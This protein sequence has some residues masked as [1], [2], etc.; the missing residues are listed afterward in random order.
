M[1]AVVDVVSDVVGGV[2][3]IV[4]DVGG[5]LVGAVEWVVDDVIQPVVSTVGDVVQGALDNPLKTMAQIAAVVT[6]QYWM[7]PLIAGA[8]TAIKG[9]SLGDVAKSVAIA[10]VMQEVA[11]YAGEAAGAYGAETAAGIEYGTS[12]SQAAMLAAQEA[13]MGTASAIAGNVLGSAGAS[14]AISVITGQD[15]LEAFLIGGATAGAAAVLGKVKDFGN[16]AANNKV[17]ADVISS[18]I[19]A[20]LSGGNVTAA[21]MGALVASAGLVSDAIKQFDPLNGQEGAKLNAAQ[22]AILSDVLMGTA[23]A[24]LSGGDPSR[25]VQAALMKA[26]SKALGEMATEGFK[27][28]TS[29]VSDYFNAAEGKADILDGNISAQEE[30]YNNY[31]AY[32]DPLNA[33]VAEQTRLKGVYDAA[34]AAHNANPTE[35]SRNTA[36]A[37]GD[38]FDAYVTKLNKDYAETYS[39]NIKKYGDQLD[40]LQQDYAVATGDYEKAMDA[41]ADSTDKLSAVLDP[42]YLESNRAFTE[43]LDPNFNAE[44]YRKING[45][46]A[47]VDVYEDYLNRGQLEGL[48]TNDKDQAI[49]EARNQVKE[50]TGQDIPNYI[51]ERALTADNDNRDEI[52]KAYAETAIQDNTK[53]VATREDATNAVLDAYAQAGYSQEQISAKI[54]SG[55]ATA[56]ANQLLE[57]QKANVESLRQYATDVGAA[58][59]QDSAEYKEA[60]KDALTAMADYG[61]YGVT[62]SGETFTSAGQGTLDPSTLLPVSKDISY[63]DPVT[64]MWNVPVSGTSGT[65]GATKTAAELSALWAIGNSANPPE[66]G[67][68]SYFGSGSGVSSGMFGGLQLV[69]IDDATGAKM[70]SGG[71]GLTLI[72]YSNGEGKVI[73]NK[74]KVELIT[75]EELAKLMG[76]VPIATPPTPAAEVK[77]VEELTQPEAYDKAK[78]DALESAQTDIKNSYQTADEVKAALESLGYNATPEE[79]QKFVGEKTPDQMQFDVEKYIDPLMVSREEVKAAYAEMGLSKPTEADIDRLVGQYAQ[80]ALEEKAAANLDA[81]RHNTIQAQLDALNPQYGEPAYIAAMKTAI[82]SAVESAKEAGLQGDAALKAAIDSVAA[83]QRTSA[84]ELL[85]SLGTTEQTLRADFE[86]GLGGLSQQ[87]QAQYAALTTA[88]KA[89]ADALVAQGKSTQ[90]AIAAAQAQ[91]SELINTKTDAINTR[92]AELVAQGASQ[93]AATTQ[94]FAEVNEKLGTQGR[95]PDQSDLDA[96]EQMISGTRP[97]DLSYDTNNDGRIDGSDLTFL[98]GIVNGPEGGSGF[99][100]PSGSPW[101][102]TGLYGNLADAE[103]ARAQDAANQKAAGEAAAA[104]AAT[105][106]KNAQIR[107]VGGQ[108]A[109]AMQQFAGTAPT[110]IQQATQQVSTPI[111]GQAVEAFDF[112]APL[113]VNWFNP[114]KEKQGSQTG[115]QTTKMASGG[116]LDNL[117]GEDMSV[118]DLLKLL[119]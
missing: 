87:M 59:G 67:G 91:S 15:P 104:Q 112:G 109:Q 49:I 106:A 96:L 80:T 47:D 29:S 36:N 43:A 71:N 82:E 45:L 69:S 108:A 65:S 27:S 114:G 35:A 30:A 46:G 98:T 92:I 44:E 33:M 37:A 16:F 1:S 70:Y 40:K 50:A 118:D 61:G 20:K 110:L 26:G 97:T 12:G 76:E 77:P 79:I 2:A 84:D 23:G 17:A 18:T 11:T 21:A 13:G 113:D 68:D 66:S 38:A 89:T 115:G 34:V 117:L 103:A 5:A 39:P 90:E 75:P 88:Q 22:T 3:D 10:Y 107:G 52:V 14:A 73:N 28:A 48:A 19:I 74:M 8:D 62:K 95:G 81:A 100:A 63:I 86:A 32:A 111:Y 93:Q 119:R 24:A 53:A 64:G 54:D 42:I 101:A 6:Q 85:K 116:Y 41:F 83:W 55:E 78:Q 102:A 31:K 105:N 9:G 99:N 51:I 60:Y 94:A 72:A 7:L 56:K 4:S 58:A 57:G 25:V